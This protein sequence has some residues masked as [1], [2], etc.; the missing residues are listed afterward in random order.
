MEHVIVVTCNW[1]CRYEDNNGNVFMEV[2]RDD[3]SNARGIA[4]SIAG[5][6]PDESSLTVDQIEDWVRGQLGWVGGDA[7]TP[8]ALEWWSVERVGISEAGLKDYDDPTLASMREYLTCLGLLEPESESGLD[9][10]AEAAIYWFAVH[11]HGGASSNL[12][13]AQCASPYRPGPLATLE[14]EGPEVAECYRAL[15]LQYT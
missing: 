13:Q 6:E 8:D 2:W 5:A 14:S 12:Y 9:G 10:T 11:Y 1:D 7:E 3:P 4:K 15:E